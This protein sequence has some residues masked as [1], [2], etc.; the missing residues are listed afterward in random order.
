MIT[1]KI[2]IKI[3]KAK[4]LIINKT[5]KSPPSQEGFCH[6]RKERRYYAACELSVSTVP[7]SFSTFL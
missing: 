5:T 4:E 6:D 2:M 7:S 3:L 1:I